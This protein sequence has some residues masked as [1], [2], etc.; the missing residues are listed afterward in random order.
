[1]IYNISI[2]WQLKSSSLTATHTNSK[3]D[4]QRVLSLKPLQLQ[5]YSKLLAGAQVWRQQCRFC[6]AATPGDVAETVYGPLFVYGVQCIYIYTNMYEF[7]CICICTYVIYA[8]TTILGAFRLRT[9][10]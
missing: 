7:D 2:L 1:M 3:G 4:F 5:D 9:N 6:Q 10:A 8:H